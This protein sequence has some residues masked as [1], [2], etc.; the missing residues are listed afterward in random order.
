VYGVVTLR[1]KTRIVEFADAAI[2]GKR[3]G[4]V[5]STMVEFTHSSIPTLQRH[6]TVYLDLRQN[7]KIL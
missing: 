6:V 7:L 3:C 2:A 1:L 5:F 4:K